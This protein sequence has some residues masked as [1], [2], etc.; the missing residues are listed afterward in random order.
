MPDDDLLTIP[1][2]LR[3]N[4]DNTMPKPTEVKPIAHSRIGASSAHRW[5]ACPGSVRLSSALPNQ[6]SEYAREGTAAHEAAARCLDL[7]KEAWELAGEKIVVEGQEFAVTDEM[8]ES[9]QLYLDTIEASLT[10]RAVKFVEQRF[11]LD[12]VHPDLYGTA[13]CV[14]FD[15]D[16]GVL[17]VFDFKYGVGIA[18]EPE[19]NPQLLT[20]AAGAVAECLKI[21]PALGINIVELVIVQPRA[22]HEDGPVRRWRVGFDLLGEWVAATLEPGAKATDAADAPLRDGEHC[23]FC[24]AKAVCPKLAGVFDSV[25]AD[26]AASEPAKMEDWELAERLSKAKAVRTYLAALESEI[27][28]RLMKGGEIPGFKLVQKKSNRVWKDGAEAVIA[29][30]L[31]EAAYNPPSLKSPAQIERL[32]G[33]RE[34]AQEHSFKP[35][36]GLTLAADDDGRPAVA[37][38]TAADAFAG[39]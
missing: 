26:A 10:E 20:Y 24:P 16:T 17:S 6:S 19:E 15:Q 5:L 30:K 37:Q 14:V 2:F 31:G 38:R 4:E 21:D 8:I 3:R 35:D 13:D 32:K 18:V 27:F 1:A 34:L 36:T 25:A 9:V 11:S 29:A 23:Q 7:G 22:D 33:G 28:S 39:V 12:E